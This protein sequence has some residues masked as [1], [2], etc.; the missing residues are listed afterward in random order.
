MRLGSFL[1]APFLYQGKV[2]RP[3]FALFLAINLLVLTNSILHNPEIGYDARDHLM[4]INVLP[5]QLPTSEDTQEFFSAPLPYFLPSLVDNACHRLN[6]VREAPGKI[7][8]CLRNAGKSAQFINVILSLG[9]TFL[10]IKIAEVVRPGNRFLKISSLALLGVMTVYYKTFAQVRGEPYVVLFAVWAIYLLSKMIYE[11]ESLTWRRGIGLGIILGLL[12]LSRQWGVTL[13]PAI[14]GLMG[15]VWIFDQ[16]HRWQFGKTLLISFIV[17][18]LISGWF[19]LYLYQEHGSFLAFNRSPQAF[20]LTN[21]PLS[22]YRGTGLKDFVLFKSPIRDIFSNQFL[23]IFYSEIWGDYWGYFVF[24]KDHTGVDASGNENRELINPYLGR[25]NA[26]AL[27]PSLILLAGMFTGIFHFTQLF[28]GDLKDKSRSLFYAFL[29]LFVIV[30]FLLF[31]YFL[32]TYP[33]P[34]QGDTIKA[35]YLLH[36]LVILPILGAEFLERMRLRY[37]TSYLVNLALLGLVFVHNLPAMITR[38]RALLH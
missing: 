23:P 24:V 35:T 33:I 13:F 30:S 29:L 36:A 3:L 17:A 21:Q 12:M 7:D 16:S 20:S 10:I 37:P 2:D 26:A 34:D 27:L 6:S 25:V 18:I 31:L 19:Y 14:L 5:Y 22:F 11:R 15:L 1:K 8:D 28:R 9:V 4:Y 38:Y 32:I